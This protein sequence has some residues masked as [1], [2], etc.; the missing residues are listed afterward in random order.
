MHGYNSRDHSMLTAMVAVDNIATGS[1]DK[2][3]IWTVNT[4]QVYHEEK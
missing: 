2:E 1:T 4:D 3:N